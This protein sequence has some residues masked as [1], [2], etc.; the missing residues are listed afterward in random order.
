V[1]KEIYFNTAAAGLIPEKYSNALKPHFKAL[2]KDAAAENFGY[3][4]KNLPHLRSLLATF[5]DAETEEIALV[6]NFSF[7]LSTLVISLRGKKRVLMYEKDYPSLMDPF[8]VNGFE[9]HKLADADGYNITQESIQLEL[10]QHKIEILAISHVQW[11]TGFKIDLSALGKFCRKHNIIFIVD[12]TQSM[13][14]MQ[15]SFKKT[16]AD[17]LITSNYKWMNAGFGTGI[18]CVRREFLEQYPPKIRGNTGRM[19]YGKKWDDNSNILGY[20]PGHHN[21]TGLLMLEEA[22]K[23][24]LHTGMEQIERHNLKLTEHFVTGIPQSE[25]VL[26]GPESMKNRSSIIALK[27]GELLYNHLN[28]RGFRISMRVGVV[29][30]SFHYQNTINEVD[31]LMVAVAGFYL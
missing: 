22:L 14:G 21:I 12:A 27:G 17:V 30:V 1:S 15:I 7:A 25:K 26:I 3:F 2:A 20:E 28:K 8:L 31:D 18:M 24:K 9:I 23:D 13:G 29:R 16:M 11:I 4:E 6:P 5:C 19:I 10:L